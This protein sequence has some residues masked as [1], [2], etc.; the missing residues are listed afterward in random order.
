MLLAIKADCKVD[1]AFAVPG[2]GFAYNRLVVTSRHTR[3]LL[4][5]ISS[6]K[7][8][9]A[10]IRVLKISLHRHQRPA[11]RGAVVGVNVRQ[12]HFVVV[13]EVGERCPVVVLP[14]HLQR[15]RE[16]DYPR[17]AARAAARQRVLQAC[18]QAAGRD[19]CLVEYA[20]ERQVRHLA[21]CVDSHVGVPRGRPAG[22]G[23]AQAFELGDCEVE[24]QREAAQTSK[25]HRRRLSAVCL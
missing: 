4:R 10:H 18:A 17:E 16:L 19:P 24:L 2:R 25:R 7:E 6:N 1:P 11:L 3:C 22:G 20:E 5:D 12:D 14:E 9:G 13:L 23:D 15:Q 8:A 21:L